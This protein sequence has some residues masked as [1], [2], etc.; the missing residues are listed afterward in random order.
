ML[1]RGHLRERTRLRTGRVVA[2]DY[3]FFLLIQV[4]V[5]LVEPAWRQTGE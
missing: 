3:C 2:E 1:R 5:Q 4:A